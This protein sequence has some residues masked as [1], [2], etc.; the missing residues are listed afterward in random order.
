MAENVI[1]KK[2]R[3]SPKHTK[4]SKDGKKTGS[5]TIKLNIENMP[6]GSIIP[7]KPSTPPSDQSTASGSITPST[8]TTPIS[9]VSQSTESVESPHT[10]K[11]LILRK[12][13]ARSNSQGYEDGIL[14]ENTI[15][16]KEI[17]FCFKCDKD[18]IIDKDGK[19][20]WTPIASIKITGW[21][22]CT[23]SDGG[24]TNVYKRVYLC[25][26]CEKSLEKQKDDIRD[27][28]SGWMMTDRAN[29]FYRQMD[30]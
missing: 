19:K 4:R 2:F 10:P 23:N 26:P 3:K 16:F 24:R 29:M 15:E 9:P 1:L 28:L 14:V 25:P 5:S 7:P 12:S 21:K 30:K 6:I 17:D 27:L 18:V 20:D 11:Q 8:P 13:I 22:M